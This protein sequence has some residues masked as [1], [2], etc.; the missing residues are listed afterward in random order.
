M[1]YKVAYLISSLNTG[2]KEVIL[3]NVLGKTDPRRFESILFVGKRSGELI[4]EVPDCKVYVGVSGGNILRSLPALWKMLLRE[5]PDIVWC[6]APGVLGFAGRL[7]AWMLRTPA[8]VISLHGRE[9]RGRLMDWPNWLIT[10]FTTDKVVTTSEAMRNA[11]RQERIPEHLLMV[12]NNGIDIYRFRPS[13][14]RAIYKQNLLQIAP[15]RPVIGTVASLSPRKAQRVLLK[16]VPRV[17]EVNPA[18]LFILAGEGPAR[19][20]LEMLSRQLGIQEH[21]RFLGLRRDIP[22]LMRS[23]DVFVLTSDY[24]PFG[25]VIVEAMATGLPVVSTAVDGT[26]ELITADTGILVPAQDDQAVADAL[27]SLLTDPDR[28]QRM[29]ACGRQRAVAHF[30]LEAMV[31]AREQL[32]LDLLEN[33][34]GLR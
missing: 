33:S 2:G 25:N 7:F 16:A 11:L 21:V 30:S 23:F 1:P 6:V 27:L 13:D 17:L 14:D 15:H 19:P 12:I 31:R 8:V 9:E 32:M 29:G 18:A 20:E 5:H 34:R 24:E 3:L 4:A 10:T 28:R 26:P 22:E